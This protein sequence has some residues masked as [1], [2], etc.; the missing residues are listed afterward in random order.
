MTGFGA[1]QLGLQRMNWL[2]TKPSSALLMMM[3]T[4]ESVLMMLSP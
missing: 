4:C 1:V 2:Q 3:M